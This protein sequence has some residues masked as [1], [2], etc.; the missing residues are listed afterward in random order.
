MYLGPFH[1][2]TKIFQEN[3]EAAKVKINKTTSNF[4]IKHTSMKERLKS[5][6]GSIRA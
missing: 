2:L 1:P 3:F 5:R 6:L 4:Q